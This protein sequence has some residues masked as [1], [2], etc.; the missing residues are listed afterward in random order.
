MQD[1]S[2]PQ[3]ASMNISQASLQK[4]FDAFHGIYIIDDSPNAEACIAADVAYQEIRAALLA[5]PK[6]DV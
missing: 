4:W 2:T 3:P 6:G 5:A 1:K